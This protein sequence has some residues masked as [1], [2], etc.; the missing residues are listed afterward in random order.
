MPRVL[1]LVMV[2]ALAGLGA[3]SALAADTPEIPLV[4]EKNR[5]QPEEM[6]LGACR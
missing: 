6:S 5:F 4:I 2:L 1:A 3:L